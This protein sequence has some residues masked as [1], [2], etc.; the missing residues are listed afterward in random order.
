[1]KQIQIL[2]T[3]TEWEM[4]KQY[5]PKAGLVVLKFSPRCPLSRSVEHHFDNWYQDLDEEI[6]LRCAKVNVV[7]A[8]ELSH[9]IA[10]DVNIA[11]ESPQ[12]IWLT[13]DQEIQWYASHYS[14]ST[15]ELDRQ[16][17]KSI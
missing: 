6:P 12:A 4:Y 7:S 11:H 15:T 10:H 5:I 2:Q 14:V 17:E 3:V 9:H 1:M 8:R 13:S 16:L